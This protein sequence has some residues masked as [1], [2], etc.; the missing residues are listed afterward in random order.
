L[1]VAKQLIEV[2][3]LPASGGMD[4]MPALSQRLTESNAHE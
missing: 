3:L 4:H 2:M 1:F